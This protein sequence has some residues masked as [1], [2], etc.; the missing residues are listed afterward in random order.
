M[1]GYFYMFK[2]KIKINT[3]LYWKFMNL[4]TSEDN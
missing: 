1:H 3:F 4:F 2:Y